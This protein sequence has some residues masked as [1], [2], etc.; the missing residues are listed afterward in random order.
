MGD[1]DG[2]IDGFDVIVGVYVG[3]FVSGTTEDG[4]KAPSLPTPLLAF[5]LFC[6][7]PRVLNPNPNPTNTINV[8]EMTASMITFRRKL[9][10]LV[11]MLDDKVLL[12][13]SL[14]FFFFFREDE[15]DKLL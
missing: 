13:L 5:L 7:C 10:S 6:C 14:P 8:V 4:G 11:L 2:E 9:L 15:E 12:L 1:V 3:S